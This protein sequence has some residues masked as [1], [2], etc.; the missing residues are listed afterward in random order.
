M[1]AAESRAM[2]ASCEQLALEMDP[3]LRPTL[4]AASTDFESAEKR[5]RARWLA[6]CSDTSSLDWIRGEIA[7]LDAEI[8]MLCRLAHLYWEEWPKVEIAFVAEGCW[9]ARV[10]LTKFSTIAVE[11]EQRTA[12]E[13]A[14][15]EALSACQIGQISDLQARLS[16]ALCSDTIATENQKL[17]TCKSDLPMPP[18]IIL[19]CGQLTCR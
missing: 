9:M 1:A 7:A 8:Q 10:Q 18:N 5:I 4:I 15:G 19:V 6:Q 13:E 14:I 12:V 17:C 3:A 11:A 2:L 16:N